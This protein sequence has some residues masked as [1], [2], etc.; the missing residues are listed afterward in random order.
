MV[1]GIAFVAMIHLS[2]PRK[3]PLEAGGADGKP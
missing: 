3:R 1:I 2:A